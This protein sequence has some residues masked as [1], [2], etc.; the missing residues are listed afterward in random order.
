[1]CGRSALPNLVKSV[2]ALQLQLATYG[3]RTIFGPRGN[4]SQLR[5]LRVSV[6]RGL[7]SQLS[8]IIYTHTLN[9]HQPRVAR[10]RKRVVTSQ[11]MEASESNASKETYHEM[12]NTAYEKHHTIF[13]TSKFVILVRLLALIPIVLSIVLSPR[14]PAVAP[15]A[16]ADDD[17]FDDFP[18]HFTF[19]VSG[20][21]RPRGS[22]ARA[23]LFLTSTRAGSC[24]PTQHQFHTDHH[25]RRDALQRSPG[26]S[27]DLSS[28]LTRARHFQ[29]NNLRHP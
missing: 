5:T 13:R 17:D 3:T 2:W 26:R 19:P 1:M 27:D 7:Y 6:Q 4:Y 10:I 14:L 23:L 20:R 12:H 16:A 15:P 22:R 25:R 29:E 21:A 24:D 18:K 8:R 11:T 28:M 9:K